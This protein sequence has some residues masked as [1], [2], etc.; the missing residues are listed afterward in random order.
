MKK[1]VLALVLLL[2]A[3]AAHAQTLYRL[4]D[5]VVAKGVGLT[6]AKGQLFY[7][8]DTAGKISPLAIGST[9]WCLVVDG[10]G[11]PVWSNVCTGVVSSVGLSVPTQFSVSGSPV[12]SSGTLALSWQTVSQNYGLFGPTSGSGVPTFRQITAGDLPVWV[13]TKGDLITYNGSTVQAVRF[14]VGADATVLTA[15]STQATGLKWSAASAGTVTSVGLTLP[16]SEL[17]VSGSPVTGSSSLSAAWHTQVKNTFFGGPVSGSDATPT[18]RVL[19]YRDLGFTTKGDILT[20]TS[21]PAFTRRA[22]GSDGQVL[23]ADSTNPTGLSW[24][25]ITGT[26]TVTSVAQTVPAFMAVTG[27][28]I[29]GAG[30]LALSFNSQSGR[31]FLASDSGVPVFRV[32]SIADLALSTK[33]DLLVTDGSGFHRLPVGTDTYALLADSTQTYGVKW[34]S[35]GVGTV[36]SVSQTVPTG[37]SISGSPVTGSGTLGI[38]LGSTTAYRILSTNSGGTVGWNTLGSGANYIGILQPSGAGHA[39]GLAPDTPGSG[40]T[41]LFLREDSSWALPPQ[42]T[43]TSVTVTVPGEM[44]LSG[45]PITASGTLGLG[46]NARTANYVFAGPTTGAPDTPAFRTLVGADI[47]VFVASGA[48]HKPGGVPDPGASAGTAKFLREDSSWQTPTFSSS[49]E[50]KAVSGTPDVTGVSILRFDSASGLSVTDNTGGIA[51]VACTSCGGGGAIATKTDAWDGDSTTVAFTATS[52]PA[53]GG[54]ILVTLN[55]LAQP[56]T[57]YS[58]T[59][60]VLTMGAAPITAAKIGWT[61]YTALGTGT[62]TIESFTGAGAT[63]FTLAHSPTADGINVVA[64]GGLMQIP[65]AYSIV[66]STTLRFA[67]VILTGASVAISYRY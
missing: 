55:G 44:S 34:S 31:M 60:S 58:V 26:G 2:A 18:F 42:G 37:F 13:T 8:S 50:V 15:D 22:V 49:I 57:A 45:S 27:S 56:P 23:Q 39:P 30:T 65:G 66:S 5:A 14:P 3:P 35:V 41:S 47:P 38:T 48:S 61:Y 25:T 17:T 21:G 40:G 24:Q 16:S 33:G 36:T 20:V 53:T 67:S 54:T 11:V 29:T 63:D 12:T 4:F 62:Q 19:D 64:V 43:M 9:G 28:P 1:I 6:P 51:T 59:S 46:W 10:S 32:F 52:T 7:S